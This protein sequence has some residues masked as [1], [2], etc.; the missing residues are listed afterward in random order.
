VFYDFVIEQRVGKEIRTST[1]SAQIVQIEEGAQESRVLI[2]PE[3]K[4]EASL[5]Y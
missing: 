1:L 2:P 5:G 3:P 4:V